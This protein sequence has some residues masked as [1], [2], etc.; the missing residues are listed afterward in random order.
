MPELPDVSVY[1]EAVR[2]RVEGRKL[3][4]VLVKSPFLLRSA[5][6][7]LSATFGR[8]VCEIRRLGKRIAIRVEDNLWLVLHLMIA[9]RLHW[10]TTAPKLGGRNLLAVFE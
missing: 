5:S 7:P 4:R 9:G 2:A 3:I 6:P 10:N 1:V 8:M